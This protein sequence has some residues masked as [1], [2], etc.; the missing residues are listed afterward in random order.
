MQLCPVP[1][2][3]RLNTWL[4]CMA[5]H[6]E[7]RNGHR[8]WCRPR[9]DRSWIKREVIQQKHAMRIRRQNDPYLKASK[10]GYDLVGG[11][12]SVPAV[13][14]G[15]A[16]NASSSSVAQRLRRRVLRCGEAMIRLCNRG[17]CGARDASVRRWTAAGIFVAREGVSVGQNRRVEIGSFDMSSVLSVRGPI[18]QAGGRK[19]RKK[20]KRKVRPR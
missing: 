17:W 10:Q 8:A 11:G 2:G 14:V 7:Q 18:S 12:F 16:A 1:V 9:R 20:E 6:E 13:S 4:V 15:L 19:K 5:V 3:H